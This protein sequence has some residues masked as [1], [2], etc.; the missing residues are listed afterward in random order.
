M[1]WID[2]Q[3]LPATRGVV[4]QIFAN[5]AGELDGLIL[6]N[7]QVVHFP[8][9]LSDWVAKHVHVGDKVSIRGL[10]TRQAGSITAV[11]ISGKDGK[12]IVDE[13]PHNGTP[14][15][16][17]LARPIG[18]TETQGTVRSPIYG[19]KGEVHGALLDNGVVLRVAPHAASSLAD[20]LSQGASIFASGAG[21]KGRYGYVIEVEELAHWI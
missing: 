7:D 20:Y 1:H 19:A 12:S 14:G 16:K 5:G 9:H 15:H 2:P 10:K 18:P 21:L 3:S 8:P 11:S 6:R 13:G 4:A 17:V